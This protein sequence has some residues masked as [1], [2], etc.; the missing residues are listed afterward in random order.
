MKS[1]HLQKGLR[2]DTTSTTY[3]LVLLFRTPSTLFVFGAGSQTGLR[4]PAMILSICLS[5]CLSV[6]SINFMH[7]T[8]HPSVPLSSHLRPSTLFTVWNSQ[9]INQGFYLKLFHFI[10]FKRRSLPPMT[11]FSK[12]TS[13]SK[14]HL[15]TPTW[16]FRGHISDHNTIS[17]FREDT[18]SSKDEAGEM[19][20]LLTAIAVLP[21]DLSSVSQHPCQSALL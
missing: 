9:R 11:Y 18:D 6:T 5:A 2:M 4:D 17:D 3:V 20:Q 15:S 12:P 1:P 7:P 19:V 13:I 16:A 8:I 14:R 10:L 21:Q